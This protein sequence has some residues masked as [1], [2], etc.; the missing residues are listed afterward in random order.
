MAITIIPETFRVPPVPP[1]YLARSRLDALWAHR[2]DARLVLVTAGAG[3]G[4]TS[5]LAAQALARPEAFRWVRVEEGAARLETFVETLGAALGCAAPA[6]VSATDSHESDSSFPREALARILAVL[7]SRDR[8]ILVIDDAHL[9]PTGTTVPRFLESLIRC[10]P[11]TATLVLSAREPTGVGTARSKAEGRVS[12]FTS[13][14]LEFRAEEVAALFA[15]R[16]PGASLDERRSRRVMAATEG[17]AA[18][19]EIFLQALES[20]LPGAIDRALER[21]HSAGSAWFDY[22]AEEVV[23]R[24]DE[25]TRDFLRRSA[26]LPRLVA[27]ICD[28]V[29]ARSHSRHL[30]EEQVRRNLFTS[31]DESTEDVYRHHHLFRRFLLGWLERETPT[32][33]L[34]ALRRQAAKVLLEEEETA[35]A[36]TLLADSGDVEGTLRLVERRSRDLLRTGRYDALEHAL[37]TIPDARVRKS[38]Q[39]LFV[40]A[41]LCD[42]RGRWEEAEAIYGQIL[43]LAPTA[44]LRVEVLSI[45]AQLV[46]RRGEYARTMALCRR[47]LALRGGGTGARHRLLA[48]LGIAACE[49]GRLEEGRR[50]LERAR[51]LCIRRDDVAG[52][53]QVDYLLAANV[54]LATGEFALG[55]ETARRALVRLRALRDPRKICLCLG[56][57]A[58]VSVL[59]GEVN[60]A[61]DLASES[62]RLAESLDLK[63]ILTMSLHVLGRCALFEGDLAQARSHLEEALR[64]GDALGESDARILPRMLLAECALAAG[65]MAEARARGEE[66]LAIARNMHDVL[67]QAQ[68]RVVLGLIEA[69]ESTKKARQLWMKAERDL[70]RLGAAFDLHRLLLLRLSSEDLDAGTRQRLLTELLTGVA[71]CRHEQILLVLEPARAAKV[72]AAAVRDSVEPSGAAALLARLGPAAVA[73]LQPLARSRDDRCRLR[74]VELLAE[75][76]GPSA[77][78]ALTRAARGSRMRPSAARAEEE[79]ARAPQLPLRIET[80][81]SMRVAVGEMEITSEKWRSARARR[82]FQFLLVH[83]FRW[84]PAEVVIEALWP[85]ADPDKARI[86]L[87]QNVYQLRRTLEPEL[88]EPRA[89]RYVRVAES[90]YRLEPGEGHT[91]DAEEVEEAVGKADR[92]AASGRVRAAEPLYARALELYQGEFLAEFPYEEFLASR[93]EHLREIH[94]RACGRLAALRASA[95]A[96]AEVV[97]LCRRA[98]SEDPYREEHHVRLIEALISLGH[99]REALDAWRDFEARISG[100]LQL[101]TSPRMLALAERIR[102]VR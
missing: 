45:L 46:S 9:L 29:L 95:R 90:G 61:R 96:W 4:K 51:A 21:L 64:L 77:R 92:L 62:Q 69:R 18:G 17:W 94:L 79:L 52:A 12:T 32:N 38:P 80:L 53:A 40:R 30:L 84:V 73:E 22:F 14:D 49:L 19:L 55:R 75:I 25:E 97:P 70:R 83:R 88:P 86:N 35:D 23:A 89:S 48:M 63:P 101:P 54:Y 91:C 60:E 34:R 3:Y 67:Q 78:A 68:A 26:V 87:W 66:A 28:R 5:F 6:G 74:A 1:T 33:R 99:R 36:L 8:I 24:L 44:A 56:V 98:L 93:R 31:R 43:R 7:R 13:K 81:G 15:L 65:N 10:L 85:E 20:P 72:L 37:E 58:W 47:G 41:R 102:G 76:G 11:D 50:H 100:E 57:L 27:R 42:D 16:F 59:A 39:A 82:L 2:S 71:R